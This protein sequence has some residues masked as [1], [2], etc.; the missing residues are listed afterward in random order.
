MAQSPGKAGRAKPWLSLPEL[1]Q[2][3]REFALLPGWYEGDTQA[4]AVLLALFY[5]GTHDPVTISRYTGVALPLLR[6]FHRRLQDNGVGLPDQGIYASWRSPVPA[7][8][9]EPMDIASDIPCHP[10]YFIQ[11]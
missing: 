6:E 5:V 3:I 1:R 9:P 8:V 7:W 4:A 11:Q 10:S 2:T